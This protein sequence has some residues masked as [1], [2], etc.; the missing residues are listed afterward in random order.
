MSVGGSA[1]ASSSYLKHP[2]IFS[3]GSRQLM[4]E[5]PTNGIA[6]DNPMVLAHM[7][8]VTAGLSQLEEACAAAKVKEKLQDELH[9]IKAMWDALAGPLKADVQARTMMRDVY[10]NEV[11][12]TDEDDL[13]AKSPLSE[14]GQSDGHTILVQ[15]DDLETEMG[16]S[17]SQSSSIHPLS[18][19]SDAPTVIMGTAAKRA[20]PPNSQASDAPTLIM[21]TAAKRARPS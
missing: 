13:P 10:L 2:Q 3:A 21:G 12:V 4:E 16:P 1:R 8:H 20:R 17:P 19:A 7:F 18:Q 5:E 15:E 6:E 14:N 11:E 9:C